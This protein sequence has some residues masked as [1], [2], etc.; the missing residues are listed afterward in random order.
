[1]L[2]LFPNPVAA[3]QPMMI[4]DARLADVV[5]GETDMG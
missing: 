5:I 3:G 1:M 4:M 2:T